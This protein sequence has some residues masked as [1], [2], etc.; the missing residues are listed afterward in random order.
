MKKYIT[1]IGIGLIAMFIIGGCNSASVSKE[2]EEN[3]IQ[4]GMS[5]VQYST[6]GTVLEVK[7]DDSVVIRVHGEEEDNNYRYKKV[8]NYLDDE[9]LEFYWTNSDGDLQNLNIGDVIAIRYFADEE[10]ERPLPVYSGDWIGKEYNGI[11]IML[12]ESALYTK[13]ELE[14]AAQ[15]VI[16]CFETTFA[17]CKMS[18]LRYEEAVYEEETAEWAEQYNAEEAII[19]VS[20]FETDE[21]GGD[22]SLNPNS[23]YEDWK[24]ILVR[25]GDEWE[26]K[27]WGY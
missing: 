16:D 15:T 23:T 24:W 27:T 10:N 13:A 12:Y 8:L 26:L 5:T 19:M 2:V 1:S 17:G 14:S 21:F 20:D 4:G 9:Q 7:E 22:G 25:T 3:A 11:N 18:D 6:L